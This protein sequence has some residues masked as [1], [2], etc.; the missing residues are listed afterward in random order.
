MSVVTVI[1]VT[2][3]HYPHSNNHRVTATTVLVL[4]EMHCRMLDEKPVA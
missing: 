3:S 1:T 2:H 4:F